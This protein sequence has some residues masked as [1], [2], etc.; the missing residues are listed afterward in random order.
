MPTQLKLSFVL[1][2]FA[3]AFS[4][5]A[6]NLSQVRIERILVNAG[7]M[8]MS[9]WT[10]GD[11]LAGL[12]R[13]LEGAPYVAGCLDKPETET[14]FVDLDALDCVT[15][16]EIS[17]ALFAAVKAGETDY[18]VFMNH[19]RQIRYRQGQV[20]YAQRLH[21]LSDWLNEARLTQRLTPV[22]TGPPAQPVQK[23]IEFMSAHRAKL[24]HLK[25]KTHLDAILATEKLLSKQQHW[26]V[27]AYEADRVM[28]DIHHG[29][30]ICFRSKKSGLDFDHVGI[31]IVE[32]GQ[33]RL[34]HASPQAGQVWLTPETLSTYLKNHHH[35]AGLE[36]WR[37]QPSQ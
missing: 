20:S 19:L 28:A 34:L 7:A 8:H 31:A 12:A 21:Y 14:L 10:S 27:P 33:V 5:S 11:C 36:V 37:V 29:D 6:Q 22:W 17:L 2:V 4:L 30:I 24:P 15:F 35:F 32:N 23:H 9:E 3:F 25:E 18:N 16:V 1:I 26:Y 13:Q